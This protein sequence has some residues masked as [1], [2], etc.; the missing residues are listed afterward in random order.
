[1]RI[2]ELF[3]IA[4]GVSM[5]AFAVAICKGMSVKTVGRRH[6]IV[7]GAWFG[8]FQALMPLIG[9]LLGVGFKNVV[10]SWDH[11][12]SFVLLSA[13]GIRMMKES[14]CGVDSLNDSFSPKVMF[15]LAVA[16]S[17]DALAVGVSFAFLN[18]QIVP[19]VLLI[20]ATT[21]IFS[22]A[23]VSIGNKFGAKFKSKAEVVG[24]A[25]LILIGTMILLE[26][27]GVI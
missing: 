4:V 7:A 16:N 5:D 11:W 14:R 2:Y 26:H 13:I 23:G 9:F 12:L 21:F 6:F 19:A 15:P 20:G 25:I 18:V 27:T 8:G 24:G 17:I 22:G 1:M 10:E 3:A